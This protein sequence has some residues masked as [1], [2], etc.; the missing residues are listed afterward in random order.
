M[1]PGQSLHMLK[2]ENVALMRG[3]RILFRGL[4]LSLGAG[5]AALLT[6]PN[7][8]GKSSLL[9]L[10]AGLLN[11]FAGSVQRMG[12][13]ALADENLALDHEVSLR[14]ALMFWARI[15]GQA[16]DKV[17]GA[18]DAMSLISLSDVP[19]RMLSTGQRKRASL[20]RTMAS[21][22]ALWL[23]D[24]PA[25]GLDKDSIARLEQTISNHRAQGGAA[26]VA[27]HLPLAMEG[28]KTITLAP[29]APDAPEEGHP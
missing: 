28:A 11:P 19:V 3:G 20:A 21:G 17:D 4:N 2:L 27:S 14:K 26:L 23:L 12:S 10:S 18:L 24:E 9:R 8:V 13:I 1:E 15:D 29:V 7:G 5:D 6:G 25:N 22:A 16:T